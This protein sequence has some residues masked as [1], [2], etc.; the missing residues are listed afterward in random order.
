MSLRAIEIGGG[1]GGSPSRVNQP[2]SAISLRSITM[3]PST[4]R[5]KNPIMSEWGNGHGCEP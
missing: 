1:I 5:A 2:A 3:S 4:H